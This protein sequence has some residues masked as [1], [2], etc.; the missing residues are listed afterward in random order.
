MTGY[1]FPDS[2]LSRLS[3]PTRVL[4]YLDKASK[5]RPSK[6]ADVLLANEQLTSLPNVKISGQKVSP[7]SK[8]AEVGRWKIIEEELLARGLPVMGQHTK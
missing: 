2:Q 8:E 1:R 4:K 6:L 7:M 5:P 3:S